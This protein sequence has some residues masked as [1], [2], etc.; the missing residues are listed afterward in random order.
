MKNDSNAG[1]QQGL[2]RRRSKRV[3][4][5]IRVR[6][7]GCLKGKTPFAEE[8]VTLAVNAHGALVGLTVEPHLGQSVD[9]RNSTTNETQ[10]CKVVFVIVA[11]DCKFIVGIDFAKPN[12]SFWQM[13]FPPEDWSTTHPDAKMKL[14]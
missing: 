8:T 5:Q 11:K 2:G 3:Y 9:L 4:V 7:E 14:A 12:P 10:Q 13:S 1:L 6:V